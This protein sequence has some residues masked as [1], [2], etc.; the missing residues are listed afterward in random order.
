MELGE[1]VAGE[2]GCSWDVV[3][4]EVHD[5]SSLVISMFIHFSSNSRGLLD[6]V[7]E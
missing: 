7:L 2:G 6:L 4:V 3:L 5:H 1:A